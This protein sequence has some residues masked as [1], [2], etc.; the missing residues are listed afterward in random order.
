MSLPSPS[1]PDTLRRERALDFL[2]DRIN[3]EQAPFPP[4]QGDVVRLARMHELLSRIGSPEKRFPVIHI[5]GTKGKGSTAAMIA[6]MLSTAGYRSGLYTSPHLERVEERM[7]IDG[8]PC[9]PIEFVDLVDQIKPTVQAM[10]QEGASRGE[11]GP[12]FF[13]ITTAMALLHFALR[14]VDVA[15]VEVGLGGVHDATNVCQPQ[16]AIITSISF[17]HTR[18]LGNTLAAIAWNKAGIIKPNVPVV[19]GVTAPEAQEV[20]RQACRRLECGAGGTGHGLPF[21]IHPPG[22]LDAG[23]A[24]G[25]VHFHYQSPSGPLEY[26]A[27][28][29]GLLGRHQAAN[30][31]VALAAVIEMGRAGWELPEHA[32]RLALAGLRWPARVE[33]VCAGRRW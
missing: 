15:V 11:T 29:L 21:R 6:A 13:E 12:T 14:R 24:T 3:F 18:Q 1:Q 28:E 4:H 33:L 30:A 23:P 2:Y 27:V 22:G 10:D 9:S 26:Q 20:V 31:A 16:L 25:L 19:S 8:R 7:A 32:V 17:D 5:A